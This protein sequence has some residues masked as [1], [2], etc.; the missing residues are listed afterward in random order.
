MAAK[1]ETFLQ[2][3]SEEMEVAKLARDE[4]WVRRTIKE[5]SENILL[6]PINDNAN[7]SSSNIC[8]ARIKWLECR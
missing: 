3:A 2:N 7:N 6:T 1:Q 4:K 5:R 8:M